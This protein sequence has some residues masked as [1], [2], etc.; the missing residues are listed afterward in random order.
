MPPSGVH[1]QSSGRGPGGQNPPE[2][3]AFLCIR[4]WIFGSAV[5]RNL[6]LGEQI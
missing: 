2:A 5:A 6:I 3:K 4:A 1:G